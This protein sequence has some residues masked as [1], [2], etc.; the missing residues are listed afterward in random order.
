MNCLLK[1]VTKKI[2]KRKIY[3]RF[4][5][6]I[7]AAYLAEMRQLSSINRRVQFSPNVLELKKLKQFF[8]GFFFD[9]GKEIYNKQIQKWLDNNDV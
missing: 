2:T 9:E 7:S 1:P 3:A 5:D 6:N 4:N 8:M